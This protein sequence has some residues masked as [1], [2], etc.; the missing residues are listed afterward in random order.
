MDSV[1]NYLIGIG[2][3]S[4]TVTCSIAGLLLVRRLVPLDVLH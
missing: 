3:V 4:L 1:P 2:I